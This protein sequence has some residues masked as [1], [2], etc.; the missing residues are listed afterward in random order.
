MT[1]KFDWR[2]YVALAIRVLIVCACASGIWESWKFDRSERLYYQYTPESIRTAI[3]V[4]PDCWWCYI[5][6]AQKDDLHAEELLRTSLELNPYNRD[7]AIDLGLRYEADGDLPRA[8]GLL[9]Q[10]FKV[11][12]TYAPRWSLANFYFRRDNLPE[13]WRWARVAAE[14]PAD[15]VGALFELCWRVSPDPGI[16]EAKILNDD[17]SLLR[18][19]ID[20]LVGKEHTSGAT[21]AGLRLARTDSAHWDGDRERL[22]SLVD[23]LVAAGDA[24]AATELWRGLIRYQ[25]IVADTSIPNNP[26]FARDPVP[27]QF[28]WTLST[29]D[30]LHSWPGVAGLETEFG[31]QELEDS[32]VAEQVISLPPGNYLLESTYHTRDIPPDTGIRW[33]VADPK[34]DSVIAS[35]ASLSSD[36]PAKVSFLFSVEPNKPFLRL[37][38]AYHREPGTARVT[39][40]VVVTSVRIQPAS[41]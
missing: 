20:F 21:S 26:Q 2:R 40:A 34:S 1:P 36:S 18:Q 22:L 8:E 14:M 38:L 17:P 37:Q 16:I 33:Q 23:Q 12:R 27:S 32:L 6:L 30:G 35:S 13:F 31:G 11:D 10:A 7:A 28:D 29:H 25:W 3:R 5:P 4:E 39:G 15:D 41:R 19:Y 24:K 9:L